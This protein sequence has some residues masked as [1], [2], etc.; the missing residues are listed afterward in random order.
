M[1]T[2]FYQIDAFA[3]Q[4]FKGNPAAVY[5]MPTYLP[6]T[7]LQKIAE[8]NN[9][10]E[11]AFVIPLSAR[12]G[13]RWFTPKTEVALCGHATLATAHM[14]FH[15]MQ[16]IDERIIFETKSGNLQVHKLPYAG[17]Y[18]LNFPAYEMQAEAIPDILPFALGCPV[19]EFYCSPSQETKD[20]LILVESA[21]LIRHLNPDLSALETLPYSG[22]CITAISDQPEYHFI[23]RFFAPAIGISEDSVTG[24]AHCMLTP[25]WGQ[26]LML[27]NLIGYQASR[28]GG[29]VICEVKSNQRICL[30]GQCH[31][32]L[33]GN[34]YF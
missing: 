32:Y 28:R 26:R 29:K 14:L 22:F 24:A 2:D 23:S 1:K 9:L 18:Q 20:V 10:A 11:T 33:K 27:D 4:A 25:F 13:L 15:E 17:G 30:S 12:Y 7:Y 21:D 34:L 19:K 8:E 16:I 3:T 5:Y 6:D 31:T